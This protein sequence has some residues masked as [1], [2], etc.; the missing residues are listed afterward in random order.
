MTTC[1]LTSSVCTAQGNCNQTEVARGMGEAAA[2]FGPSF[3]VSTGDNVYKVGVKSFE[4]PAWNSSWA[5][6][7]V[8]KS[9][10]NLPWHA[11]LGNHGAPKDSACAALL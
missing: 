11:V 2:G 4:D 6:V 3:V 8:S 5:G 7:Y 1:R 10:E 9:L